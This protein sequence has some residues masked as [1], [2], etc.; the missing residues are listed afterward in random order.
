MA[1]EWDRYDT[2]FFDGMRGAP[3]GNT[4]DNLRQSGANWRDRFSRPDINLGRVGNIARPMATAFWEHRWEILAGGVAGGAVRT[5]SKIAFSGAGGIPL[6]VGAGFLAGIST[7]Y[8]KFVFRNIRETYASPDRLTGHDLKG[9]PVRLAKA[10]KDFM[11]TWKMAWE[12]TAAGGRGALAGLVGF[13]IVEAASGLHDH[14][15][16]ASAQ[17]ETIR[18]NV[19]QA[20][21]SQ[22]EASRGPWTRPGVETIPQD[23]NYRFINPDSEVGKIPGIGVDGSS[24]RGAM[25]WKWFQSHFLDMYSRE[26][27]AVATGLKIEDLQTNGEFDHN[28]IQKAISILDHREDRIW[29][30]NMLADQRFATIHDS[31]VFNLMVDHRSLNIKDLG[32]NPFHEVLDSQ[33][34]VTDYLM[35]HYQEKYVPYRM[36]NPE[37]VREFLANLR[38]SGTVLPSSMTIEEKYELWNEIIRK[39]RVAGIEVGT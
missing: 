1:T 14:F 24:L 23:S 21:T 32:F 13:G 39:S 37:Q 29:Y 11:P 31:E 22:R 12:I 25:E 8:S 6:S 33:G 15:F 34:R 26:E 3:T 18:T 9:F 30:E 20:E 7:E 27:L 28:K 16:V 10:A 5:A 36:L 19:P 2:N 17:S 38:R 35:E 4:W